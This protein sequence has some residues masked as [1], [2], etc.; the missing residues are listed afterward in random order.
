MHRGLPAPAAVALSPMV[1][2]WRARHP[3]RIARR[4]TPLG[5]GPFAGLRDE[6]RAYE[7]RLT[8]RPGV[9][10]VHPVLDSCFRGAG[11]ALGHRDEQGHAVR[12]CRSSRGLALARRRRGRHRRRHHASCQAAPGAAAAAARLPSASTPDLRVRRRR[13]RTTSRRARRRD[14]HRRRRVGPTYQVRAGGRVAC[15]RRDRSSP[16][17]LLQWLAILAKLPL[18]RGRPGGF[19]A[20]SELERG[21][22]RAPVRS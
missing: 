10:Q 21:A 3:R 7:A 17:Q 18:T 15:G 2:W 20:G 19:D 16:A 14:T 1:A 6:F 11:A 12:R 22:C 8:R 9:P 4:V 13:R 5:R